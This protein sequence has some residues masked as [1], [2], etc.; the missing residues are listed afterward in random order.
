MTADPPIQLVCFD[1]GGVVV[2][3]CPD[4]PAALANVGVSVDVDWARF[5]AHHDQARRVVR[6]VETGR[7]DMPEVCRTIAPLL[8]VTDEQV[9]RA[10]DHW[11]L[12][13]YEGIGELIEALRAI[14]MATCC[15]S[16][17]N[18]H[19]WAQMMGDPQYRR[20]LDQLDHHFA[21]HQVKLVKPEPAIF[22]HVER[23]L[24]LAG[25]RIV[26]FDDTAGH[27]D[28][29]RQRRWRGHVIDPQNN[30]PHQMRTLLREYGLGV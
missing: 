25:E 9:M 12:E 15:L 22:E 19:H 18:A 21:S 3:I 27:I 4:L 26:Y 29:A 5:L 24:G 23:A 6:D 13:V 28:A 16:N 7:I 30:P 17:T 2:R 20:V 14:G 8:G 11:L 10:V 1:L